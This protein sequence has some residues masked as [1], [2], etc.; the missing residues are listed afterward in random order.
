[1]RHV[2]T[3]MIMTL[4]IAQPVLAD[5]R[6][7][8]SA[9]LDD[10]LARAAERSA[11]ETFWAS[12]LVYTS[13]AGT[14]TNKEKILAGFDEAGED[15][16]GSEAPA[17]SSRYVDIRLYGDMAV[18]AFQLV[19]SPAKAEESEVNYFNTGTFIKRDGRW[20]AVAWQATRIPGE[21]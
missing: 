21:R 6:D 1:M 13:S 15:N 9:L 11:H 8:L 17:Y 18:V 20:Q 7:V 10:F 4:L 2:T 14:R 16:A 19:A 12:E 5:E 3:S